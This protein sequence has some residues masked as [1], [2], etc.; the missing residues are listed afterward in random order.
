MA[1]GSNRE[2]GGEW[3][4]VRLE[5]FEKCW[6]PAIT[7]GLHAWTITPN[8]IKEMEKIQSKFLKKICELPITT[9]TAALFMETGVWPVTE[10][11]DYLTAMLYH[12]MITSKG[13]KNHSGPT[14]KTNAIYYTNKGVS[15]DEIYRFKV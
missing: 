10:T 5:L 11:I 3:F 14:T 13:H 4:R 12:E 9:P 6:V 1:M 2:V 8:E 15:I 7:H